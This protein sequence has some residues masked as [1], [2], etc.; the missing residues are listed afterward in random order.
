MP[1]RPDLDGTMAFKRYI[2]SG[3]LQGAGIDFTVYTR[4]EWVLTCSTVST[5]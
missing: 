3:V 5:N 4:E 1:L 2:S